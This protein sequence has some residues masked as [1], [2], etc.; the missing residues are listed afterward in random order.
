MNNTLIVGLIVTG[1]ALLFCIIST[2][3]PYW[4]S[5][6]NVNIG[7]FRLCADTLLGNKCADLDDSAD[8]LNATRAM[9]ILSIL[10]LGGSVLL[11]ILFGFILKDKQIIAIGAAFMSF[12]GAVLALLGVIIFAAKF[13]DD[14]YDLVYGEGSFHASFGLAIIALIAAFVGGAI[15]FLSRTRNVSV[16]M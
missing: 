3:I 2:A 12:A 15:L 13:P 4:W 1:I 7:L 5:S 10:S 14:V 9:M 8:W 11:A 6:D 16:T